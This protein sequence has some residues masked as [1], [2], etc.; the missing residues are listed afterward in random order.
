MINYCPSTKVKVNLSLCL[1][2]Y[3]A[4]KTYRALN[5]EG[6]SKSFRTES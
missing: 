4:M 6:V 2:N 5:Y 1:T 3:N